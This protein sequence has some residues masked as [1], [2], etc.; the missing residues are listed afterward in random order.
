MI[1]WLELFDQIGIEGPK[2]WTFP[3]E[4]LHFHDMLSARVPQLFDVHLNRKG[5]LELIMASQTTQR[6]S[7]IQ[8]NI[9]LIIMIQ[10]GNQPQVVRW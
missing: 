5:M 7:K 9:F 2:L 10:K 4:L 3:W 1:L 8:C 6:Y